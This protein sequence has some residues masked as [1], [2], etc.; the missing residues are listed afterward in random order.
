MME[1]DTGG[2]CNDRQGKNG[3]EGA[4]ASRERMM[5]GRAWILG[6]YGDAEGGENVNM[7]EGKLAEHMQEGRW[8]WHDGSTACRGLGGWGA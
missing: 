7:K 8:R 6:G 2:K 5:E 4:G 1:G 3:G